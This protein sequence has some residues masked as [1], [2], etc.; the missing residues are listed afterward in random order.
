VYQTPDSGNTWSDPVKLTEDATKTHFAPWVAGQQANSPSP[1]DDPDDAFSFIGDHSPSGMA[2]DD[3]GGAF[4]V[5]AD[6]TPG[7]RAI[8]FSAI[9]VKAFEF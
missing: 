9:N 3:H 5:W 7:E 8:F 1:L 2:L 4:V 6:W